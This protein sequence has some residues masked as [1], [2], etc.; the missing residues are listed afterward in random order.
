MLSYFT[1]AGAGKYSV[2]QQILGG[3]I[4]LYTSGLEAIGFDTSAEF[5]NPF[6]NAFI[7]EK[8]LKRREKT[9]RYY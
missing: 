9:G 7:D 5:V 3:E 8:E 4:E 2:D 6:R 1:V